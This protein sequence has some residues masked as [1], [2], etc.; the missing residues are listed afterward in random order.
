MPKDN[1]A[2]VGRHHVV[3]R[4]QRQTQ[5]RKAASSRRKRRSTFRTSRLSTP[6][7]RQADPRRFQAWK[8]GKQGP[9]RQA[10][11]RSDRWLTK[12]NTSPRLKTQYDE[13]IKRKQ[14][15]EEFGYKN[16]MQV[17]VSTKIV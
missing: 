8:D 2:V 17:R 5:T 1:R 12:Q 4:H 9:R 11:G 7:I 13:T 3:K 15:L 16:E 6:R 14:L 10:F